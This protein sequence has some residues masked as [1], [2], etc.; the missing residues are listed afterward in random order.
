MN[1]P[2]TVKGIS[3]V[4]WNLR[5]ILYKFDNFRTT[6]ENDNHKVYCITETWLKQNVHDNFLHKEGYNL[7]RLDRIALNRN[8]DI[9]RGGGMLI[10]VKNTLT[11]S[12]MYNNACISTSKDVEMYT[13]SLPKIP[14]YQTSICHNSI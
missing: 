5:S 11:V 13:Y 3:I 2:K 7:F 12:Q 14:S 4:F 9:K 8:G 10:Y 6:V 1:E